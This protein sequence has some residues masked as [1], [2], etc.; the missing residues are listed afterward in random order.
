ME[1]DETGCSLNAILVGAIDF[2]YKRTRTS[3]VNAEKSKG[4][5]AALI[6]KIKME[7]NP[8]C[9]GDADFIGK[10][11]VVRT[12]SMATRRIADTFRQFVAPESLNLGAG[13]MESDV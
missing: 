6:G 12:V 2:G 11:Q 10:K 7:R 13:R 4:C 3:G 9:A 1:K 8:L 5:Y